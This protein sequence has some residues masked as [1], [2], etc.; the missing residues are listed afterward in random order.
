MLPGELPSSMVPLALFFVQ[1]VHAFLYLGVFLD[2]EHYCG[3]FPV[4]HPGAFP[5]SLRPTPRRDR[6]RDY[7]GLPPAPMPA[8]TPAA[9]ARGHCRGT[10]HAQSAGCEASVRV[11]LCEC[12]FRCSYSPAT[13]CAWPVLLSGRSTDCTASCGHWQ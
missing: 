5:T 1:V 9:A 8:Y 4:L 13:L 7:W 12:V 3:V 2:T 11:F 10:E 6:L